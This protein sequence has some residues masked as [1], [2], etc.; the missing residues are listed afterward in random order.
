MKKQKVFRSKRFTIAI[1]L[2]IT[3]TTIYFIAKP[4]QFKNGIWKGVIQRA[5]GQKIVFNFETKDSVG[6]KVIYVINGKERLLVDS[7][8]FRND[9]VFIQ[10]P[11]FASGFEAKIN[12]DG[13]L[14]GVWIRDLGTYKQSLPFYATYNQKKRFEI[15]APPIA[16]ISGRWSAN[17]TGANNTV[18]ELVGEFSQVGS[19]LTG[20]FREP[21]GDYRFLEGVVSGDSLKL[22]SFDGSHSFL[23]TAKIDNKNKISGGKFY[24]G[25]LAEQNWSAERNDNAELPEASGET[26]ITTGSDKLNFS[27]QDMVDGHMVSLSDK[28]F[29]NKV[30]VITIMGS[31]CPNCMDEAKFLTDYYE[32]NQDKGLEIIGL[33]FERTS[34]FAKSQKSLQPFKKRLG[35]TYPVL[36]TGITVGEIVDGSKT[37]P[38]IE[39]IVAFPSTI[40]VDKKG[41]IRKITNGFDGPATGVHHVIFKK[42]F[43]KIVTD[44]LNEK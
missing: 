40:F 26:K 35:V 41:N 2:L 13:N 29:K 10:M 42:D 19:Y 31:W 24:A 22:S 4:L 15:K 14:Q 28:Q 11:F 12:E 5:D 20:T 33:S 8:I 7:I 9:S 38:P 1:L 27:F 43:D 37:L 30:M 32:K 36:I 44:L 34:D 17:F 18:A 3:F 23:F 21:T 39:R 25:I 16:N 6:K